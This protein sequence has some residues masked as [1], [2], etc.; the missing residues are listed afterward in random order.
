MSDWLAIA[1]DET[2]ARE[3]DPVDMPSTLERAARLSEPVRDRCPH[4]FELGKGWCGVKRCAGARRA[5]K[6]TE[7]A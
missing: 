6:P 7:A 2:E 3:F 5:P 4:G 1:I